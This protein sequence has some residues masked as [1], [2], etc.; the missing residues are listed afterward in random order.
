MASVDHNETDLSGNNQLSQASI[1]VQTIHLSDH[2]TCVRD[3][4]GSGVPIVLI[5]A[6]AMDSHMWIDHGIFHKLA[7][8]VDQYGAPQRVLCYDLRGHGFAQD[9]PRITSLDQVADDLADLL[10]VLCIDKVDVMGVSFGGGVAQI[11][12][13]NHPEF[14]RSAAFIATTSRGSPVMA[15]CANLA[16]QNGLESLLE[17]TLSRWFEPETIAENAQCVI[18]AR[19]RL[20]K[21][22]LETWAAAWRA[23]AA[24][25]C[26]HR[27]HEL[28][29]PVLILA[30]SHDTSTTVSVMRQMFEACRMAD[31][32]EIDRGMHLFVIEVPTAGPG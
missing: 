30:G 2:S 18:F 10:R 20:G 9:A 31:Y 13:L 27:L 1:D 28:Q 7:I 25:D 8:S 16:E 17:P 4:G 32:R 23:I 3:S 5:H 29:I 11:F 21:L 24:I 19:D 22:R 14:V 15:D 6:L 26:Q 12:S